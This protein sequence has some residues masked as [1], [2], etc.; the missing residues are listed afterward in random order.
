MDP[1]VVKGHFMSDTTP[2]TVHQ[3]KAQI[4]DQEAQSELREFLL[5]HHGRVDLNPLPS[6]S[7]NDPLNWPTWKKN[8]WI[9]QVAFHAMFALFSSAVLI[10][11]YE[12]FVEEY[13]VT[14]TQ[15]S[16]LTSVQVSF[17]S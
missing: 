17:P 2:T 6:M 1:T 12:I 15:A 14:L 4:P 10:P 8:V 11:A 5:H 16:Y 7:L 3:E 13:S 9:F